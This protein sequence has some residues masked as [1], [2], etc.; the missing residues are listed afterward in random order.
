MKYTDILAEQL[1]WVILFMVV[2]LMAMLE[3]TEIIE[4]N[5]CV[6]GDKT[7]YLPAIISPTYVAVVIVVKT[8][9]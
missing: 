9:G 3:Y 4:P 7:V 5:G 6:Y 8:C 1:W 2:D